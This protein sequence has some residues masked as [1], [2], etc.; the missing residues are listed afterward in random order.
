MYVYIMLPDMKGQRQ[1]EI[2][3]LS[4]THGGSRIGCLRR[5]AKTRKSLLSFVW[6]FVFIP[7]YN[8]YWKLVW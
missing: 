2:P 4:G 8:L 6:N 5:E 7:V 3:H 1:C